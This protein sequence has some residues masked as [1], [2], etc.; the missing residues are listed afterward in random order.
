[1]SYTAFENWPADRLS[2]Q[3]TYYKNRRALLEVDLRD[4]QKELQE[5]Y[6]GRSNVDGFFRGQWDRLSTRQ[7]RGTRAQELCAEWGLK[8]AG[9]DEGIAQLR[10]V[11]AHNY[12]ELSNIPMWLEELK[13]RMDGGR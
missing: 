2:G 13:W 11:I 7:R 1:M 12:Q 8:L 4:L 5:L 6:D 9:M 3:Y 10:T